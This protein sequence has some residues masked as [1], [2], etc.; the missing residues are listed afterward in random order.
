[1][2]IPSSDDNREFYDLLLKVTDLIKL[3]IKTA[4]DS[5]KKTR[6]VGVNT[7]NLKIVKYR[8]DGSVVTYPELYAKNNMTIQS[9]FYIRAARSEIM[10]GLA[11]Q[12]KPNLY[13]Q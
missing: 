10:K 7:E 3:K 12:E 2:K 6:K 1:M 5:M 9:T 4:K 8:N 11:S 13:I